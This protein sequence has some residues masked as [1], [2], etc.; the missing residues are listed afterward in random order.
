MSQ[1]NSVSYKSNLQVLTVDTANALDKLYQL[2]DTKCVHIAIE[3]VE[4]SKCHLSEYY[5]FHFWEPAIEFLKRNKS[6]IRSNLVQTVAQAVFQHSTNFCREQTFACQQLVCDMWN[7]FVVRAGYCS[8]THC[9]PPIMRWSN[10]QIGPYTFNQHPVQCIETERS[11]LPVVSFPSGFMK[12]G[13][14]AWTVLGHEVA[15]TILES[16]WKL[17]A[18]LKRRL[19]RDLPRKARINKNLS[20]Y[21]LR[22]VSEAAADVMNVLYMGPI[23]ALGLISF[24]RAARYGQA[25]SNYLNLDFE[26][27]H[28]VDILR[29]ILVA[30]VT[31]R[32][33]IS[34][35]DVWFNF[36][37]REIKNDFNGELLG[38][39][40]QE[41]IET[42]DIVA[43]ALMETRLVNNKS[44][45]EI[46]SWNMEDEKSVAF[47]MDPSQMKEH[48]VQD[49]PYF[50]APHIIAS[51][52]IFLIFG[53]DLR[54]D[55]REK[56][57]AVFSRMVNS[58][59]NE[60][61]RQLEECLTCPLSQKEITPKG[62]NT[63]TGRDLLN[64]ILPIILI[65]GVI[66][67]VFGFWRLSYVQTKKIDLFQNFIRSFPDFK[68]QQ[69]N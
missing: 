35:N 43:E 48:E 44:L 41:A 9:L 46:T 13:I 8:T 51:A 37:L 42:T 21:W 40:W 32:L 63:M 36:L 15:H 69:L 49:L 2:P 3:Q 33:K 27:E 55:S 56:I 12:S 4:A 64:I 34:N 30:C 18:V 20:Q 38:M 60:S 5:R 67:I 50:R 26:E 58:L 66:V 6:N 59:E 25:L 17:S 47:Y 45:A 61:K 62:K 54:S 39:S 1:I 19:K 16:G 10:D 28:P 52:N 24:L 31:R 53:S 7:T 11:A 22:C 29:A 68:F 65:L 23:A 14:L 57:D